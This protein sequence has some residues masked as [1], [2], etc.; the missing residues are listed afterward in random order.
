MKLL[1]DE[2][3]GCSIVNA[4]MEMGHDV[5]RIVDIRSGISDI[6][7]L[8]AAHREK[9]GLVTFDSD[10]GELIYRYLAKPPIA[11]IYIRIKPDQL[12]TIIDQLHAILDMKDIKNELIVVESA[13]IRRRFF[14]PKIAKE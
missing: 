1:V 14:P 10:F 3:I 6:D 8:D 2:N 5:V 7:V 12:D 4:L 9:R 11:L 13:R